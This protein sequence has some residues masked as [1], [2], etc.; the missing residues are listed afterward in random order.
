[1]QIAVLRNRFICRACPGNPAPNRE[2]ACLPDSL[3]ELS[4][5]KIQSLLIV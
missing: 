5:D 1:M 2:R 4:Y 3:Y